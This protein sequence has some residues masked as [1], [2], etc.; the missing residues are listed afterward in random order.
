[1]DMYLSKHATSYGNK[2]YTIVFLHGGGYYVSDKTQEE[3]YIEPYLKKGLN[4]INM[5]YRLKKGIPLATSDLTNALNFLH[6]NN[7]AYKLNL[8]NVI[9]TGFSAGAHIATNVGVNPK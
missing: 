5:N 6:T 9:V 8:Y 4:V 7:S 1:M 3:K 2:N